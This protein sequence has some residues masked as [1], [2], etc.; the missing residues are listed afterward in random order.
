[1]YI[2]C[3]Y[4]IGLL[5]LG[6]V[7]LAGCAKVRDEPEYSLSLF[8]TARQLDYSDA[9]R[10]LKTIAKHPRDGGKNGDVGHSWILLKGKKGKASIIIE[11]GH[12]GERGICQPRYFEGVARA[13]ECGEKNPIGYLWVTQKDGFFQRGSGGHCPTYAVRCRLTEA[14]FLSI[15]AYIQ[16]EHY[17]YPNYSLVENQC[18]SFVAQV[19]QIAGISLET[20]ITVLVPQRMRYGA[21]RVKLWE[22]PQYAA[23][24]ISSPDV[25]EISLKRAVKEGVVERIWL[26]RDPLKWR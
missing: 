20:S 23:L 18:V 25:L 12:S 14:Q 5:I 22:D 19:A 3:I 8:V 4:R 11:G 26:K 6:A 10:L 13:I 9:G 1:M 7:L 24:T 2:T 21:T 15:L 17:D 16:P